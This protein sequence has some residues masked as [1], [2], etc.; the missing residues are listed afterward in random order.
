MW[1]WA[2][3]CGNVSQVWFMGGVVST[4]MAQLWGRSAGG[5]CDHGL[6]CLSNPFSAVTGHKQFCPY[7]KVF[8]LPKTWCDH[9]YR[10][11]SPNLD[12]FGGT[13]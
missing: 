1:T 7:A 5:Y 9:L 3:V 4:P 2:C 8:C 6:T 10:R 12:C 13:V 11:Y